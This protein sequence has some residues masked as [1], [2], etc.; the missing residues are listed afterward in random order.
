MNP[1]AWAS[2]ALPRWRVGMQDHHDTEQ[3][4]DRLRFM[5]R[6]LGSFGRGATWLP[7]LRGRSFQRGMAD[8]RDW[9]QMYLDQH[10]YR[11]L[12][13]GLFAGLMVGYLIA[14]MTAVPE[15]NVEIEQER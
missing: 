15:I 4:R 12:A 1:Y 2:V 3:E 7:D 8:L 6:P 13:G 5:R 14:R 9:W 11:L 10:P